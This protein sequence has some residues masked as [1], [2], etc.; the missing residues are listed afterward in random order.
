MK[1]EHIVQPKRGAWRDFLL[2]G[3]FV[4]LLWLPTVDF[5][6]GI[7]VTTP[8]G[9]NRMPAPK[10][11]FERKSMEGVQQLAV[12]TENYFNDHFGFRKRLIR[13]C[14]QWK[15]RLYSDQSCY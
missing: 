2:M 9:E 11:H 3:I 1:S 13:W 15:A 12:E 7:D 4:T 6:T 14:L 5:I 10:P 8:P